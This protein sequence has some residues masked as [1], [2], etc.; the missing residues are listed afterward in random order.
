[1][2]FTKPL[3]RIASNLIDLIILTAF[4]F[5]LASIFDVFSVIDLSSIN[6]L[7]ISISTKNGFYF[8]LV[9]FIFFFLVLVLLPTL[10]NGYTIGGLIINVRIIKL[11]EK[12]MTIGTMI[13]REILGG[14]VL[15]VFSFG[16]VHIISI[17]LLFKSEGNRTI[18]DRIANTIVVEGGIRL[19]NK[20]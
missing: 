7:L 16:L 4:A 12:H 20:K 14:F 8:S 2:E 19:C 1:M 13:I 5:L 18:Y 3:K 11:N 10:D 17:I 15:T 9:F 6:K